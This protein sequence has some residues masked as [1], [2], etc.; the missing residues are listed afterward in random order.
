MEGLATHRS[1]PTAEGN[2]D[3]GT[4]ADVDT[5]ELLRRDPVL[6][7]RLQD[8]ASGPEWVIDR[9]DLCGTERNKSNHVKTKPLECH[10][11][12]P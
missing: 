11:F 10:G 3:C 2:A 5:G 6:A 7:H 1:V 4:D 12:Q 9:T 8:V